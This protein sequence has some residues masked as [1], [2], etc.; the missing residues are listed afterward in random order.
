MK[1]LSLVVLDTLEEFML[2]MEEE[3]LQPE[4]QLMQYVFDVLVELLDQ[5][6]TTSFLSCLFL[7]IRRFILKFKDSIFLYRNTTYCSD[8]CFHI[9]RYTNSANPITRSESASLLY[10]MIKVNYQVRNN[11]ARTKLQSTI[12]V[13]RLCGESNVKDFTNLEKALT[14]V[15]RLAKKEFEQK[16]NNIAMGKDVEDLISRLFKIIR[17]SMKISEYSF[18]P[19]MIADLTYAVSIGYKDSPDLRVAW[20]GNLLRCHTDHQNHEE[21]AQCKFLIIALVIES[22][23]AS[24]GTNL[25]GIPRDKNELAFI[26][27]NILREPGLSTGDAQDE[28]LYNS[29]IFSEQGLIHGFNDAAKLLQ[30]CKRFETSI[31]MYDILL[32]IYQTRKD[33]ANL[34]RSFSELK[35]VSELLVNTDKT[36]G[37]LFNNYYRVTFFGEQFLE[38]NGRELIYKQDAMIRLVDFSERLKTQYSKFGNVTILPNGP[39]DKAKLNP[40][41]V[42]LQVIAV[43]PYFDEAETL[44]RKT[45]WDRNFDVSKFIYESPFTTTG[46]SHGDISVQCKKKTILSTEYSFPY[47]KKRLLVK[48]KMEI[49]LS[50]IETA[51][52]N[53]QMKEHALRGELNKTPPNPKTLQIQLQGAVL[54]RKFLHFFPP[55]FIIDSNVSNDFLFLKKIIT[56]GVN[57]GKRWCN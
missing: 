54:T 8:L 13:S 52:E 7:S 11:F 18:D 40:L 51:I 31:D 45:D 33:Y 14:N 1:E 4:S 3:L 15:S 28:G 9:L 47:V 5:K 29:S 6:Q 24:G 53:V 25:S 46:E 20:L 36:T 42:Y 57:R 50:P 37:R 30:N 21:A 34:A 48:S 38:L 22:L 35:T 16:F 19:E 41:G 49:I 56:I 39:V 2:D 44:N 17:D 32:E 26:S 12:A 10:L 43:E 27:P 23:N 55:C